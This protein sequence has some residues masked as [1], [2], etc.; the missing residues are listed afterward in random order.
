MSSS[1]LF[2]C[3]GLIGYL[4]SQGIIDA[5]QSTSKLIILETIFQIKDQEWGDGTCHQ[6][7]LSLVPGTHMVEGEN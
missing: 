5:P 7:D 4:L 3:E 2:L 1:R 6:A